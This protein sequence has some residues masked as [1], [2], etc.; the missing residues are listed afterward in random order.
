MFYNK[1]EIT[2]IPVGKAKDL[3]GQKFNR[4]TVLG[5][6]PHEYRGGYWWC[7]CNCEQHHIVKVL[8][9]HLIAGNVKSCGCLNKEI[10]SQIGKS[11]KKDLVGQVFNYL[12]V[13]EDSG[14]RAHNRG[15]IWTC[16]CRCGKRVD[17][18]SDQLKSNEILS[19]GCKQ[20]S[21]GEEKIETILQENSIC[22][23]KE[24]V[25]TNFHFDDI[26][27]SHPRFDFYLP[28]YNLIIEYDGEQHFKEVTGNKF[29]SSSLKD[30]QSKDLQK[31]KYCE[32]QGI[33][34]LRIPY[35]DLHLITLQ[36]I[37]ERSGIKFD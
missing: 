32:E 37:E 15:I 16:E 19:C 1:N 13:I 20:R 17:V 22:Y 36:L 3:T 14:K 33:N 10:V 29:K 7:E 23:E 4:L 11:T 5:R 25:F 34:L 6:A 2:F 31:N 35:T 18:R 12:T 26:Q 8:G 21:M 30:R 24:K 9:S 27:Q 28:D